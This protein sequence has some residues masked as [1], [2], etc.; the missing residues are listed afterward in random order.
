MPKFEHCGKCTHENVAPFSDFVRLSVCYTHGLCPRVLTY[1]HDVFTTWQ[2]RD[3]SFLAPN[4]V[5]T[6]YIPTA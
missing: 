6:V 2:P 3:S 5:S 4:F 1:D